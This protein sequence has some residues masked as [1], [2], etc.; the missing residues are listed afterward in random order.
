MAAID[1]NT[2]K[3]LE[4]RMSLLREGKWRRMRFCCESRRLFG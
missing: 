3:Q 1:I 2:N 4:T